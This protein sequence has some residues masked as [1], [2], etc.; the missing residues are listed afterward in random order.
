[1]EYLPSLKELGITVHNQQFFEEKVTNYGYEE[2][3]LQYA[4]HFKNKKTKTDFK[5]LYDFYRLDQHLKNQFM[6]A[7]QLF[8][9][10][11]KSA[12][13]QIIANNSQ[14]PELAEKYIMSDGKIVRRGDLKARIRHLKLNCLDPVADNTQLEKGKISPWL[15]IKSMSFG[16]ANNYFFLLNEKLRRQILEQLFYKINSTKDY[17][18]IL[19]D[20]KIFR[21]RAAHNYRLIGIKNGEMYLYPQILTN[22]SYLK[23]LEPFHFAQ[24]KIKSIIKSFIQKYPNEKMYLEKVLKEK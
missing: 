15:L 14:T 18:Q 23:N 4:N 3:V 22:L 9:Q 7:L 13:S 10:T 24:L 5:E 11:F 20:I 8:E 17:E 21:N 16:I 1:M 2:I 12:M 19:L 6:I